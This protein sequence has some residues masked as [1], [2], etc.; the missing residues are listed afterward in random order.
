M[1]LD[2]NSLVEITDETIIAA[3][4]PRRHRAFP[5][6]VRLPDGDILVGFRMGSDHH[7]TH[8]GA[9]YI[10]R[11]SD[12]GRH[13]T[14]PK[15]LAAYPG[16]DVC[17]V[18]GQYVD[19]VMPDDEPFLWARLMMYRWIAGPA[20]DE[21]YR[22]YQTLWTTSTDNGHNWETTFPLYLGL[23]ATVKTDRGEMALGGLNPHSYSS[24]LM[25]LSDGTVMGM[26]VGNK[27]IMKYR[28]S[29]ERRARGETGAALTEMPLAGFSRDNLR[30]WEYVVVADPDEYGI[31][32]SEADIVQLDTG[33]IVAI[34]GNNQNSPSFFRTWSDDEGRTWAP[35]KEL[36]FRGDSPSMVQLADGSLLAAIRNIPEGGGVGI[37]LVASSDGG[38]TW[39][40]LGNIS[41]QANWDMAYPDLIKLA[42][43]NFLCVFYTSAE[44]KMISAGQVAALRKI[45]PMRTMFGDG[46]MRP[47]AYEELN[48]EIRGMFIR[49]LTV[50]AAASDHTSSSPD[51][52]KVEL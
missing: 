19:G 21:D 32:F 50:G 15:V 52:S 30:T 48:G 39:Q 22:T 24:T 44:A 27:E 18:M 46:G 43:R 35:M 5:T 17:A 45:E 7:M 26:F 1:P 25:R 37:G 23:S 10:T 42:D 47:S 13:W 3:G 34:Y 4:P 14:P 49:D 36:S 31:G 20:D 51:E 8:D 12:G 33:R 9:F 29:A 11:S 28:K 40:T 16:W 2:S 6:G 41:D 38:E